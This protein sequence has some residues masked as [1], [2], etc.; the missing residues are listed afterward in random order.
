MF[1]KYFDEYKI[2]DRFITRG[3]TITETDL[4]NF[5]G[6]SG[7]FLSLHTDAEYA[8]STRFGERIAHGMLVLSVMTGLMPTDP[9]KVEAL[10]GYDKVRFLRPVLIGD[11]VRVEMEVTNLHRRGSR[12]GVV[13]CQ[14][15][16]VNQR[17]EAVASMILKILMKSSQSPPRTPEPNPG[18][19]AD[20]S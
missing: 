13:D 16:I 20:D 14:M 4:V 5:S 19:N 6:V 15:R 3:R 12:G 2:G 10:Y 9:E 7:D 11:T 1:T 18:P 17:G 8:K